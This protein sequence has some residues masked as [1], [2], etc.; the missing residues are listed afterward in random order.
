MEHNSFFVVSHLFTDPNNLNRLSWKLLHFT[1]YWHSYKQNNSAEKLWHPHNMKQAPFIQMMFRF[2]SKYRQKT[3]APS[4]LLAYCFPISISNSFHAAPRRSSAYI[5]HR[6]AY[7][8]AAVT[9]C[10]ECS[11]YEVGYFGSTT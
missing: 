9:L 10:F 8:T 3:D 2:P 4:D 1:V 6:V 7:F 5:W 11:S